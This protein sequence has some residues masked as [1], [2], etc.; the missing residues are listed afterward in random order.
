MGT[1][2]RD[3]NL[4][5]KPLLDFSF[6]CWLRKMAAGLKLCKDVMML[7][8]GVDCKDFLR[9]VLLKAEVNCLNP[10]AGLERSENVK[11]LM[12]ARNLVIVVFLS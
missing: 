5:S 6:I 2:Y 12:I 8:V 3:L 1:D 7:D 10:G 11:D 9:L 4:G